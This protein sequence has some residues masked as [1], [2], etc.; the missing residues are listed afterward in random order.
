MG[1][2]RWLV[3]C[4]DPEEIQS[5]MEEHASLPGKP[6][7]ARRPLPGDH[8]LFTD[9]NVA[10]GLY[11]EQMMLQV[12]LGCLLAGP[13]AATAPYLHSALGFLCL[14]PD[15]A[16]IASPQETEHMQAQALN[17]ADDDR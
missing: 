7:P 10:R 14:R 3:V 9:G 1:L 15:N 17:Q 13:D 6:L 16:H 4:A 11:A 12:S 8:E 2:C 5:S